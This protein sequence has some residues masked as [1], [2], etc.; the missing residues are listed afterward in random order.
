MDAV[1]GHMT[2][3]CAPQAA[4]VGGPSNELGRP[5]STAEASDRIFGLV[6]MNDWSARDVQKWEATPLGPFTA[7]NGVGADLSSHRQC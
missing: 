2:A 1:M 6:L 3:A 4:L 5:V 7:K